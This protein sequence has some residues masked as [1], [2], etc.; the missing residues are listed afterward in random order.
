MKNQKPSFK[1]LLNQSLERFQREPVPQTDSSW[2]EVLDRHRDGLQGVFEEMDVTE[3]ET[4]LRRPLFAGRP[5]WIGAA[6]VVAIAVALSIVF[7]PT[8]E[9]A[10]AATVEGAGL[11]RV[12]DAKTQ[13]LKANDGIR[14]GEVIRS[15][16]GSNGSLVLADGSRIEMRT[17][18]EL[19][20]ERA[21]DGVRIRLH[22][23]SII[24]DAAPQ[25][26]G[27]L[28][29]QTKDLTVSVIGTVFLVNAETEGSRVAVIE[30]EVHV[31]QGPTE[32]KL[33][34]GEQV[35]SNPLMEQPPVR[36]EIAWS[37]RVEEHLAALRQNLEAVVSAMSTVVASQ[38]PTPPVANRW[39]SISIQSCGSQNT[40]A[41]ARGG[42]VGASSGELRVT[43]MPLRYLLEMAYVK[44]LE[45][46]AIRPRW[47]Y[48]IS[49]G[50]TWVDTELYTIRARANGLQDEQTLKGPMLQTLLE[51]RFKLKM[52]R[53]VIE[54]QVYELLDAGFKPQALK[55]GDCEARKTTIAAANSNITDPL[56]RALA[57]GPGGLRVCG[58]QAIGAPSDGSAAP[59]GTRTVNVH[60][61]SLDL[62]IRNLS[63]DRIVLDRTGLKGIYDMRLTYSVVTSPMR[64]PQPLPPGTVPGGDS[65]FT[66]MEQ[67]LGLRLL[68]VK[69][70]RVYYTVQNVDRPTLD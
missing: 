10:K 52:Q 29:V 22:N 18:S 42:G 35:A 51:D 33:R 15:N 23:G 17:R 54:E 49:G 55:D 57:A 59:P 31:T 53:D 19:V 66:A 25:R 1:N 27:H 36:Q 48:P 26:K 24:V 2:R 65:I 8:L 5:I 30:G 37:P 39:E 69:G 3:K 63:L 67:Q 62:L 7:L 11:H 32:T 6:A 47:F 43:C 56:M 9:P 21:A 14:M 38:T 20:L 12:F 16:G 46:D 41:G 50:P 44:W 28:Y 61:G 34:S 4:S 13:S 68:P 58:F 60:G 45:P 70:P 64:E 40:E